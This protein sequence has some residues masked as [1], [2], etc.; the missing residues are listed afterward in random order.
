MSFCRHFDRSLTHYAASRFPQSRKNALKKEREKKCKFACISWMEKCGCS[1]KITTMIS[2]ELCAHGVCLFFSI[3]GASLHAFTI[4]TL[5]SAYT[6]PHQVKYFSLLICWRVINFLKKS[7]YYLCA[8]II[9]F[10]ILCARWLFALVLAVS[11]PML[12]NTL[13]HTTNNEYTPLLK[14]PKQKSKKT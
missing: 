14:Q 7:Y 12:R 4:L 6:S 13:F 5:H 9:G 10:S 11:M 1:A 3:F 8:H 2:G